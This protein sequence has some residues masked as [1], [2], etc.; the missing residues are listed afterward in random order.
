MYKYSIIMVI[1]KIRNIAINNATNFKNRCICI[2]GE[3]LCQKRT[4]ALIQVEVLF[5]CSD[6][7]YLKGLLRFI[8]INN[9][10]GIVKSS[11]F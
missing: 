1:I 7:L 8:T 5:L 3:S 4:S 6:S 10:F 2:K 9:P 11:L